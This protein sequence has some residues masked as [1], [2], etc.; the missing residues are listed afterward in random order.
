MIPLYGFVHGDTL[1][2]VVIVT[3]D[4]TM[5]AVADQLQAS[6]SVRVRPRKGIAVM[7]EGKRVGLDATVASLRLKPLDRI[8]IVGIDANDNGEA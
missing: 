2:L 8:D 7:H 1:G 5:M 3:E 4:Q 6:A